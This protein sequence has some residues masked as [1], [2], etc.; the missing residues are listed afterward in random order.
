[1]ISEIDPSDGHPAIEWNQRKFRRFEKAFVA[2]Y[3][4]YIEGDFKDDTFVFE[5]HKFPL[6]YAGYLITHLR[7]VLGVK[8]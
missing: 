4:K 1:M 3:R 7:D 2:A 5:K 6:S 8:K